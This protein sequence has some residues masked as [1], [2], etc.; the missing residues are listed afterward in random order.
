MG[1]GK[2]ENKHGVEILLNRTWQKESSGLNTSTSVPL[3]NR[4]KQ[5]L[6]MQKFVA[7]NTMYRKMHQ[8]LVKCRTLEGVERQLDY[9][10]VNRKYLTHSRDAEANDMIH[11]GSDHRSVMARFVIPVSQQKDSTKRMHYEKPE[12]ITEFEERYSEL[13]RRITQK[14]NVVENQGKSTCKEAEPKKVEDQC[15]KD[16]S[17]KIEKAA[18]EDEAAA[19]GDEGDKK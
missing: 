4:T 3:Q 16:T 15:P 18:E 19:T 11:M 10:L 17:K 12:K 13:E 5:W 6:M 9:I 7:L 2:F 1:A 14:P 8:K